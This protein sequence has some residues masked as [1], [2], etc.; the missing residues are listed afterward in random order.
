VNKYT[1]TFRKSDGKTRTMNFV[2]ERDA[3]AHFGRA[4]TTSSGISTTI[5]YADKLGRVL[6]YDVDVNN[7]RYFNTSTQV[8]DII[9]ETAFNLSSRGGSNRH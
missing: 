8:G 6:V 7:W 1:G 2:T 3:K 9:T 4:D 5:G